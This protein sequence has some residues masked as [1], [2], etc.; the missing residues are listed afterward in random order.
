[1]YKTLLKGVSILELYFID[2]LSDDLIING[3]RPAPTLVMTAI[4]KLMRLRQISDIAAVHTSVVIVRLTS[5]H[6]LIG[7][8]K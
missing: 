1:M 8:R 5:L 7:F 3:F 2:R 6:G 4:A